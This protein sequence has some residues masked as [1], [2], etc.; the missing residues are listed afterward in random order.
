MKMTFFKGQWL[1]CFEMK[2]KVKIEIESKYL[3]FGAD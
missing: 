1:V 2:G 3:R